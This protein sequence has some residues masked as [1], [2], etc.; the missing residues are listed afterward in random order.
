MYKFNIKVILMLKNNKLTEIFYYIFYYSLNLE[1]NLI[2]TFNILLSII[3][4]L[5]KENIKLLNLLLNK[6][7]SF[8]RT[9]ST[10]AY[11]L[12]LYKKNEFIKL[13]NYFCDLNK[14]IENNKI[15]ESEVKNILKELVNF[16]LN[17][18]NSF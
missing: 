13:K 15:Y 9:V 6:L 1:L 2:K 14:T 11:F 4:L 10:S 16:Y 5:D 7:K 8:H 12:Y 3:I 17:I 18:F